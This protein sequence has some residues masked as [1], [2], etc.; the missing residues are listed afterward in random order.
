[1]RTYNFKFEV[2]CG[3]DAGQADLAEVEQLID[4][5]MQEL[6]YDDRFTAALGEDES[7]TIRVSQ[8]GGTNG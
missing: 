2:I 6:V 3:N 4:I 5:S 1:M 7:V 8:I